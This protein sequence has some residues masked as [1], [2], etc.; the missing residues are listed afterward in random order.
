MIATWTYS[1]STGQMSHNGVLVGT[2]YSGNGADLNNPAKQ[3]VIMHGPIPKGTYTIGPSGTH[4]HL[5]PISMELIP[6]SGNDMCGRSA[7]FIHGDNS[8]M[9]HSASDGC[10]VLNA[11]IRQKIAD[12]GDH[13][14]HVVG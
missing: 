9:D 10:I 1:Q 14:L 11:A 13:V 7:F 12:S 6:S 2:G 4:G 8:K 3:C 5:G